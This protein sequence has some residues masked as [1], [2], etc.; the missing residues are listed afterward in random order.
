MFP[1]GWVARE[2]R[3]QAVRVGTTAISSFPGEPLHDLGLTIKR[4]GRALGFDHVI[5]ATLGNGHGS[6]FASETE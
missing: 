4:D 6:Y 1:R 2:F 5:P 3:F